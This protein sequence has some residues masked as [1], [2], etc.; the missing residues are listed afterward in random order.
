MKT[1]E[2]LEHAYLAQKRMKTLFVAQFARPTNLKHINL[3]KLTP[4]QRALLVADG[5]VTQFIE[6]YTLAPVDVVRIAQE[7]RTL[8][9]DHGWLKATKGTTMID[10]QVLLQSESN[11][12]SIPIA[13]ANSLI[14]LQRL[15]KI[16]QEGLVIE[17]EGLGRLL[18][19]SGLETRRDLLWCGLEHPDDLPAIIGHLN[20]KPFLSRTY[21]I[22]ANRQPLMLITEKFPLNVTPTNF[23]R[24]VP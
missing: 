5:T 20:G 21:R 18:R 2:T 23:S 19:Q 15:P 7:T 16:I 4:F 8:S 6:A 22:V 3:R 13:L 9:A 10:R 24:T 11:T 12:S 17:G 14:V 1:N